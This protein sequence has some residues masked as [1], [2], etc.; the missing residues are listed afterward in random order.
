MAQGI[1]HTHRPEID[2]RIR[3]EAHRHRQG[4]PL[5]D[6]VQHFPGDKPHAGQEG[7]DQRAAEGAHRTM[8]AP[9]MTP[10]AAKGNPM[11]T[12]ANRPGRPRFSAAAHK[13]RVDARLGSRMAIT[14]S[15]FATSWV[16]R[17]PRES[18]LASVRRHEA[19]AIRSLVIAMARGAV[20]GSDTRTES[21]TAAVESFCRFATARTAR[22][23]W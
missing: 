13:R 8:R 2:Q 18:Q 17:T 22:S 12:R 15:R 5:V 3:H 23:R 9:K 7:P 14:E 1:G 21:S 4:T 10:A 20:S 6:G 19:P 16:S 11:R